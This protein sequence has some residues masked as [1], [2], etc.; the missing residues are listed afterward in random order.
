MT[1]AERRG[2][3]PAAAQTAAGAGDGIVERT[4]C[5]VAI[6]ESGL[7]RRDVAPGSKVFSTGE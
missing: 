7:G 4:R 1:S 5:Q 2:Q 3:D 6:V